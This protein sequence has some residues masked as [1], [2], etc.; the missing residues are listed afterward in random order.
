MHTCST[1]ARQRAERLQA[2]PPGSRARGSFRTG[3]NASRGRLLRGTGIVLLVVLALAAPAFAAP[4]N[5]N[6]A[7]PFNVD[8]TTG[9]PVTLASTADATIEAGEFLTPAG[10]GVCNPGARKMEATTWYRILGNGGTV[11]IDTAGS[12]FDTVLAVYGL[13]ASLDD[14]LP[15][16]DDATGQTSAVSFP[17]AAG[18]AYLVQVGGCSGCGTTSIGSLVM[19]VSATDPPLPPAPPPPPP[20]LLRLRLLCRLRLLRRRRRRYRGLKPSPRWSG[21]DKA[22]TCGCVGCASD[23]TRADRGASR[24]A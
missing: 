1:T 11:S 20:R 7:S 10:A 22:G 24:C 5:D 12:N 6:Q 8:I 15:C 4:S 23:W 14:G 18:R 19:H 9:D 2:D 3:M 13:P 21:F 16:N 17:S